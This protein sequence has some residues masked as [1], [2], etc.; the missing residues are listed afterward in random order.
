M[1]D[2]MTQSR[3]IVRPLSRRDALRAFSIAG[4][5]ALGCGGSALSKSNSSGGASGS[6]GGGSGLGGAGSGTPPCVVRPTQTEGPY[7]IDERLNR[8]DIRSDPST[9]VIS[10][11]VP[12]SV[13]M[14]VYHAVDGACMPVV[15]ATVDLWQ[16]DALGV[17]SDVVDGGGAFDTTGQQ[18]LRGY[19]VT[20][21]NGVVHFM[22]IYP[23]WYTGRTVHLHFKVRTDPAAAT[24]YQFTSQLYFDDAVTDAVMT[25]APYNTKTGTRILNAQDGIFVAGGQYLMLSL[26][27][28]DTS[29]SGTFDIGLDIP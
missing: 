19:Q 17:Y 20:D 11:G 14:R 8:T 27:Q 28:G 10:A 6:T 21:A 23:G 5:A 15:G 9:G 1:V 16:C 18:F 22:T 24:G 7:F 4:A 25:Q 3:T 29:Y 2:F 26:T 12:L 13:M